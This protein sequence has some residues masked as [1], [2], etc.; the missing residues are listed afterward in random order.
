[1]EPPSR[2]LLEQS[3][4]LAQVVVVVG[5]GGQHRRALTRLQGPLSN[6]NDSAGIRAPAAGFYTQ[7]PASA[8][9]VPIH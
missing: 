5:V 3:P 1:V 4:L 9:G 2:V 7:S 6:G 8:S